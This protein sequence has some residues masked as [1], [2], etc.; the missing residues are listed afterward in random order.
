V[1]LS[2]QLPFAL[3]PLIRFT[4]R[5]AIMGPFASPLLLRAGGWLAF[6][7]IATANIA[8]LLSL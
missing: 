2:L 5:P 8:L 3:W 1:V 4:G 7:A 6:G